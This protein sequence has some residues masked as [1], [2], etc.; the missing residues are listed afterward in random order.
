MNFKKVFKNKWFLA[1]IFVTVIFLGANRSLL[2]GTGV[3]IWDVDG[4]FMLYQTL[5]AD[6][7]RAGEFMLWDV[8]SNGGT[9]MAGDPQVGVFSPLNVFSG[10]LT[11]G[12]TAGFRYYWLFVWWIGGFGIMMLGRHFKLSAWLSAVVALGYL[13][14]GIYVSNAQHTSHVI[15]FSFIP[16]IIWRLDVALLS[17]RFLPAL[18]AGAL[19]GGAA[20]SS[21]P[22]YTILT[23]LY[24]G[25]WAIGRWL[26]KENYPIQ[27][28]NLDSVKATE[29]KQSSFLFLT[30][31]LILATVIGVL[32]LSP[33]YF[34]F[35]Y[36]SAGTTTRV[37]TLSKEAVI[38]ENPLPLGAVSTFAS[39]YI[40]IQK[41]YNTTL[42]AETDVS[43]TNIYISPIILVLAL[44]ALINNPR[45]K[46]RWWLIFLAFFSLACSMSLVFP[47][48]GWLYDLVYP[49]RY[50][51]HSSIFRAYYFFS[52]AILAFYGLRDLLS[53]S[54]RKSAHLWRNFGAVSQILAVSALL[55][56]VSLINSLSTVGGKINLAY[57]HVFFVWIGICL[58]PYF[59]TKLFPQDTR[60]PVTALLLALAVF[61]A[62]CVYR[63]AQSFIVAEDPSLV[64]RWQKLDEQHS[65]GLDLTSVGLNRDESSCYEQTYPC[66]NLN[67]DQMIKKIPV[68]NSYGTQVN[69]FHVE[70]TKNPDL[71]KMAIGA[72]RIWF[73][74][75]VA[76]VSPTMESFST[77]AKQTE[78]LSTPPLVVHRP[79]EMLGKGTSANSAEEKQSIET[80]PPMQNIGVRLIK[81]TP[82][83]LTFEAEAPSDGWLLV[84]DRWARSWKAKVNNL[85][86]PVYGGNFIFRAVKVSAGK[87]LVTFSYEPPSFPYLLIL[88]WGIM[89]SLLIISLW[90]T[91]KRHNLRYSK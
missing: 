50:F 39:P 76:E 38:R 3:G 85:E 41:L 37:G 33:T 5:V 11:G 8:W 47:F 42:W 27:N 83:E 71:R 9:P 65:S 67:N 91:Y 72:E 20:L 2:L 64:A 86:T 25:L 56:F 73:S 34:S 12:S 18:Q 49:T 74:S 60:L 82:K 51:R 89:G 58:V 45:D 87:N 78:N 32:I 36:E 59:K 16:L 6:H 55:V 19:W 4:Q 22:S 17:K 26:C 81:Y 70:I 61:D 84:T 52:I 21:Y 57:V 14:S 90:D 63:L 23:I 24:C 80:L 66:K 44:F 54:H 53:V 10:L 35:L 69:S 62:F 88:S 68:L 31:S 43:M 40:P 48:R 1:I 29:T 15:G 77:F 79:Q 46:W 7:A 75:Q 28:D 13:F 30:L